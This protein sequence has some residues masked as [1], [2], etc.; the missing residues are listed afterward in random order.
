MLNTHSFYSIKLLFNF[1]YYKRNR[2]FSI[3]IVDLDEYFGVFQCHLNKRLYVIGKIMI[4]DMF[5]D[6]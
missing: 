3:K 4:L 1:I 5:G 6:N 2:D